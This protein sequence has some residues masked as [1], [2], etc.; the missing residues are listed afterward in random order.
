MMG[1]DAIAVSVF[2]QFFSFYC[3]CDRDSAG[4][5]VLVG[6][7]WGVQNLEKCRSVIGLTLFMTL[8]GAV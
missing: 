6:Q 3:I 5:T 8:I 1:V 2:F 4:T 7:A